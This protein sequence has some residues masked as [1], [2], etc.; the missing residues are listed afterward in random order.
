MNQERLQEMA[1]DIN[2]ENFVRRVS[3]TFLAE[4]HFSR[5]SN[6]NPYNP[7]TEEAHYQEYEQHFDTLTMEE[8]MAQA[9][10]PL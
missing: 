10:Q 2:E 9:R 8:E 4:L 5:G 7:E 3:A 1:R 6:E